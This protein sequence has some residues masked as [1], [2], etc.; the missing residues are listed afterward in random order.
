MSVHREPVT[1]KGLSGEEGAVQLAPAP[2]K[3]PGHR[4]PTLRAGP[5]SHVGP[6]GHPCHELG[7][8]L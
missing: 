8:G 5:Q 2:C 3:G 4:V 1:R 6:R 7:W